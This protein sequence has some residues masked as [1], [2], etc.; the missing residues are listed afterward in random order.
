MNVYKLQ[1]IILE[2]TLPF[3]L[4]LQDCIDLEDA[5]KAFIIVLDGIPSQLRVKRKY[6]EDASGNGVKL[7]PFSKIE[8][9]RYGFLS[10]TDI[11]IW[12]DK[13]TFDNVGI[14]RQVMQI[15]HEYFFQ[16]SIKYLN[17]FLMNYRSITREY[18]IR[19]I[20][21]NDIISY[22]CTLFDTDKQQET[23][24]KLLNTT[25][26][27]NG[28]EEITISEDKEQQLRN[29]LLSHHNNLADDLLL[30]ALDN[31]DIGNFNNTIIQCSILFEN[32]IYK[33]LDGKLTKTKLDKIKRKNG[34]NC[35]VGVYQVCKVGLKSEFNSDFAESEEF[36]SF[37]KKVLKVR[38]NL[39]HGVK[40]ENVE[41]KDAVDAI[42][43]TMKVINKL[44]NEL[45]L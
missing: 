8:N 14:D 35:L 42:D 28:G 12:F 9:D 11:Q 29:L 43:I 25:V 24:Y 7:A 19:P 40:L 39:V 23:S 22:R 15:Q 17:K 37:H 1:N 45:G 44:S 36:I 30:N 10:K 31:L 16:L 3:A 41:Y 5:G 20:K 4:D 21:N 34:C 13:Q 26:Y 6:N 38:N 18:W 2:Y 27:F 33:S 32:F